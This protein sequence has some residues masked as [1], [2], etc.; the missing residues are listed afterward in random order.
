MY[1]R[2]HDASG[3]C[4]AGAKAHSV[5]D[6]VWSHAVDVMAAGM[7]IQVIRVGGD[8][9]AVVAVCVYKEDTNWR[10]L[11]V[12]ACTLINRGSQPLQIALQS[13][14]V[15][16]LDSWLSHP[17]PATHLPPP[18]AAPRT[19]QS[20]QSSRLPQSALQKGQ[21]LPSHTEMLQLQPLGTEAAAV[22]VL[23]FV[24]QQGAAMV[25]LSTVRV[26]LGRG[27]GWSHPIPLHAASDQVC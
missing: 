11:I 9:G 23:P 17:Q 16:S 6:S 25:S 3:N 15:V 13:P 20:G 27:N 5:H 7:S 19:P 21:T 4:S 14:R 18:T 22:R 26:W 10:T 12:P 2:Q 1:H 24:R 8:C